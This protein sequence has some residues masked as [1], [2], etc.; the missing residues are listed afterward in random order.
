MELG[1][2]TIDQLEKRFNEMIQLDKCFDLV[3]R[4]LVIGGRQAVFYFVDGM[5]KDEILEKMMQ[6]FFNITAEDMP[7]DAE[8]FS[9]EHISYGETDLLDDADGIVSALLCGSVPLFI[10]G[11]DRCMVIDCR[12][13]PA[14]S[15]DEPDKDKVLR[16][17]RDGFVETLNYNSALIRRRIRSPKLCME[18]IRVGRSSKTDVV[19]C[20]YE[21]REDPAF[22]TQLKKR[23]QDIDVDALTMNQQSLAECLYKGHWINPLPKVKYSERP[24]TAAASILE[25]NIVVLVDNSP[26]AMIM[27]TSLFDVTEEANDYYFPPVTGTYLRFSR[28][29]VTLVTLFLTPVF[30]LLMQN[31]YLIPQW[32]DF[33][34]IKDD[35]H[36]ALV[37]QLLI[38]ELA[39]DGM[40]LAALNTPTTLST[41]FSVIAGLVLGEY[42][43]NSGWFNAEIM[44]YMAF[45]AVANYSQASFELG[46]ALKFMRMFL[47]I[48]VACFNI[49]GFWIGVA[50]IFL[51]VLTNRTISGKSYLYPLIPFRWQKLRDRILRVHLNK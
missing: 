39:I 36:I 47:L 22:L 43:V 24:D 41:P 29:L 26:S 21:G 34:M 31:K 32:L 50:V 1:T 40:R 51:S 27:P 4:R 28:F 7:D 15:V 13:Y 48:M 19:V 49:W 5:V 38:L 10:E 42:A 17:S 35:I 45:V 11:Y 23:I 6:F 18:L 14:R 2:M 33:I 30:L 8:T 46:Y 3:N 37:A 20:Y 9:R 25:G 12:T 44:L 16:G